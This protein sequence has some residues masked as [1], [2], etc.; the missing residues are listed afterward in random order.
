MHSHEEED[1][2]SWKLDQLTIP[3]QVYHLQAG[4]SLCWNDQILILQD[5]A[6]TIEFRSPPKF[7][8]K[9]I[10]WRF[11]LIRD[12]VWSSQIDAFLLLTRNALHTISPKS[13]LLPQSPRDKPLEKFPTKT[14]KKVKSFSQ[15]NL[16]WRCTCAGTTLYVV[17]AGRSEDMIEKYV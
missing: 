12:I 4:N 17:Y 13:L 7:Q 11:G 9:R 16:F 15:D 6:T 3:T 8:S 10:P 5:G 14:Y 2:S 1:S